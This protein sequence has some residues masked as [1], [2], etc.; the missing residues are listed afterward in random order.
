LISYT[1]FLLHI[2]H[3]GIPVCVRHTLDER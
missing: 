3:C 1:L 2:A